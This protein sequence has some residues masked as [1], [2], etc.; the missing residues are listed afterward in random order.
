MEHSRC[1]TKT[2][3]SNTTGPT[4]RYGSIIRKF[5]EI[6]SYSRVARSM[7]RFEELI[8]TSFGQL[9]RAIT[10]IHAMFTIRPDFT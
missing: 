3:S 9:L 4:F 10:L 8:E 7:K 1:S 2:C 6:S 5:T